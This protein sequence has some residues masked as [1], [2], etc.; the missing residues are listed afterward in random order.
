MT[1]HRALAA[2]MILAH[3]ATVGCTSLREIPRADYGARAQRRA[4]RVE[5]QDGL[6]YDFDY[7]RF[8]ADSVVGFRERTDLDGSVGQVAQVPL[9]LSDVSRV[10]ARGV[11]W[12]RTALAGGGIVVGAL[13]V[14]VAQARK[15][16]P[17]PATGGGG[18]SGIL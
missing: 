1:P 15:S 11:D 18:K 7:A 9:A 2:L 13:I 17:P 12:R 4:V 14:T 5:T 6:V 16:D 3:V 10:R 8:S